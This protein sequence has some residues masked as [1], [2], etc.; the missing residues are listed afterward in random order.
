VAE[1]E[2]ETAQET[3]EFLVQ[4]FNVSDP[5]EARGNS[6]TAREILDRGA[7]DIETRLAGPPVVQGRLMRNIGAVYHQLG[8]YDEARPLLERS[9]A[10]GRTSGDREELAGSLQ[11]LGLLDG[12]QGRFDDAEREMKEAL[13]LY[14]E[15]DGDRDPLVAPLTADLGGVYMKWQRPQAAVPYL[16]E[17][18]RLYSLAAQPDSERIATAVTHL[19]TALFL[20]QQYDSAAPYLRTALA[21]RTR[22][23]PPDSPE[24]GSI[25][26]NLGAN[27]YGQGRYDD[28]GD[29]YEHARVIFEKV[30]G[31]DHP[32]MAVLVN[33][34]AEVYWRQ[35]R[36]ADAERDFQR[37]LDIMHKLLPPEHPSL[38]TPLNG[39]ANVY[40]DEGRYQE[41]DSLYRHAIDIWEKLG[42]D[43][44]ALAESL[45]DYAD[46]L[47]RMGRPADATVMRGRAAKIRARTGQ[48]S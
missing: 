46:L 47:D 48:G 2:A 6:I 20:E 17:A 37:A 21:M 33:N 24:L 7:R 34:L 14:E 18:L 29:A 36:Y 8:L 4:L 31:P 25:W 42:P 43:S 23:L 5:S 32:N 39:L 35:G 19:G 22:F 12:D 1:Q 16:R 26:I 13:D 30:L 44:D 41:A 40:R 9:V 27:Y 3:T 38:A 45:S 11:R 15:L 28:A 10:L